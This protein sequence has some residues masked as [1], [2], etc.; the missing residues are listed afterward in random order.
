MTIDK[1]QLMVPVWFYHYCKQKC[2]RKKNLIEGVPRNHKTRYFIDQ[3]K[4]ASKPLLRNVNTCW[5]PSCFLSLKA[6]VSLHGIYC[7]PSS[8]KEDKRYHS[9]F[10]WIKNL[11]NYIFATQN[12]SATDIYLHFKNITYFFKNTIKMPFFE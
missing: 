11:F 10:V 1:E 8:K 4:T 7:F 3:D 5:H 2:H 12:M 6:H 9:L